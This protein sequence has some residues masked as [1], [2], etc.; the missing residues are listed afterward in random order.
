ACPH[1]PAADGLFVLIVG[2]DWI[3]QVNARPEVIEET[4]VH[5]QGTAHRHWRP[6]LLRRPGGLAAVYGD[7]LQAQP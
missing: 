7:P 5:L 1:R 3:W 6:G 2:P 4:R